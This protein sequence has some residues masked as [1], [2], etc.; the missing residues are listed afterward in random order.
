MPVVDY[1]ADA[2]DVDNAVAH[3]V[4]DVGDAVDDAVAYALLMLVVLLCLL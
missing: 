1:V 4:V 2:V 3:A